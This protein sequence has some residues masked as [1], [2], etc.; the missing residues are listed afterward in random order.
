MANQ[1]E[2]LNGGIRGRIERWNSRR[3]APGIESLPLAQDRKKAVRRAI[4]SFF[5]CMACR[6]PSGPEDPAVDY[7]NKRACM[8]KHSG[9]V[10]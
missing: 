10:D 3:Y 1:T 6:R 9:M 4:K 5:T 8:M 7:L 2:I